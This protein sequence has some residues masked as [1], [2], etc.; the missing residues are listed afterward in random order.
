MDPRRSPAGVLPALHQLLLRHHPSIG[1]GLL[2]LDED[3][4]QSVLGYLLQIKSLK[5][6]DMER[7]WVDLAVQ[8]FVHNDSREF[9]QE[10][11]E[12]ISL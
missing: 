7:R 1:D 5:L 10:Y 4:V 11:R 6:S 3:V 12:V 2:L 9:F 8:S